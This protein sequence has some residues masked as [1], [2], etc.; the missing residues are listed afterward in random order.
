MIKAVLFDLDGTLV[1]SLRDLATSSNYALSCFGYPVHPEESY[2]IFVGDGMIKLMERILPTDNRDGET[3]Q[4]LFECF[5]KHYGEHYTDFTVPYDGINELISSLKETGLK[6]AVISNKA[7]KMAVAVVDKLFGDTFDL[8]Y[9]KRDG[10]PTKPNPALTLK[11]I[12]ELGFKPCECVLIGD[13]GMDVATAVNV[14]CK[15]V[16]VLWGFRNREELL[17]NGAS[18][19]AEKPQDIIGILKE[20]ENEI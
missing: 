3:V 8:V 15:G 12:D 16:G 4:K 6:T 13:S 17:A 19:I 18:Y 2:K 9:G 5:W 11:L 10:F 20:I 1:N 14:G 7:E